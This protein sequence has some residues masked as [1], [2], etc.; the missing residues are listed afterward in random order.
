MPTLGHS[1]AKWPGRLQFLHKLLWLEQKQ[2]TQLG[3][4]LPLKRGNGG[5]KSI[6]IQK[7]IYHIMGFSSSRIQSVFQ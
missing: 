6:Y 7:Q 4:T 3:R 2:H 5:E 1:L